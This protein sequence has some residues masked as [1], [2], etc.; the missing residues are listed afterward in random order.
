M[1]KKIRLRALALAGLSSYAVGIESIV[2]GVGGAIYL[3]LP[4]NKYDLPVDV[5]LQIDLIILT[6]FL[7]MAVVLFYIGNYCSRKVNEI[8]LAEWRSENEQA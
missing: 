2:V 3:S 1:S 6:V 5:V 4:N 8:E 7:T